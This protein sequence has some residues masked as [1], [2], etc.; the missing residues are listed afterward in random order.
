MENG[1]VSPCWL[2]SVL[3]VQHLLQPKA[4]WVGVVL[5]GELTEPKG[6]ACPDTG[7]TQVHLTGEPEKDNERS[8]PASSHTPT[9]V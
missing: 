2:V 5:L 1:E 7:L 8:P 9:R 4:A 3:E 6:K